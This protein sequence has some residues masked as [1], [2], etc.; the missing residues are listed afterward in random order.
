M[1]VD[2]Y[3]WQSK[4]E[5]SREDEPGNLKRRF[6]TIREFDSQTEGLLIGFGAR[7]IH[8]WSSPSPS[9]EHFPT[10]GFVFCFVRENTLYCK[11]CASNIPQDCFAI[12]KMGGRR[13]QAVWCRDCVEYM[14]RVGRYTVPNQV[15]QFLQVA[16][17][18]SSCVPIHLTAELMREN[19]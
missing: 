9:Y 3:W 11:E 6:T 15:K 19:K 8:R 18:I 13:I 14:Q 12:L 17:C 1:E 4:F 10:H 7:A 2:P 5:Y 16:P